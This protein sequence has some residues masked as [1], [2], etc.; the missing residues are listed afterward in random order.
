[1]V[2]S[3]SSIVIEQLV[4]FQAPAGLAAGGRG[5]GGL[6]CLLTVTL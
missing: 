3:V 4:E 6:R 2:G 1:M 5:R